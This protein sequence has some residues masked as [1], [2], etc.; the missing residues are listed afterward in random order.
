M[1]WRVLLNFLGLTHGFSGLHFVAIQKT[2]LV[3]IDLVEVLCHPGAVGRLSPADA[4]VTV[5]IDFGADVCC[6][7]GAGVGF[8]CGG[9]G[10]CGGGDGRQSGDSGQG[11]NKFHGA[12][13]FLG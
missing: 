11:D 3:G 4:S 6:V 8:C 2:I 1:S 9:L 12:I 7:S 13:S 5:C 10:Q